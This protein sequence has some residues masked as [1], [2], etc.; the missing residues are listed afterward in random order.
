MPLQESQTCHGS[1][2]AGGGALRGA[3][4]RGSFYSVCKACLIKYLLHNVGYQG[5]VGRYLT[6]PCLILSYD[7]IQVCGIIVDTAY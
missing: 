1:M 5:T 7:G 3:R 6:S 2:G 4:R